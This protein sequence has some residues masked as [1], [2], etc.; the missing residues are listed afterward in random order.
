MTLAPSTITLSLSVNVA[1]V[2]VNIDELGIGG[3]MT[4]DTA[5]F[6]AKIDK[7]L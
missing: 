6:I 2:V 3:N 5:D 4:I 7:V 1:I